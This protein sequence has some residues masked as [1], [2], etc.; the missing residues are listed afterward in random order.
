MQF[1]PY[2]DAVM[3]DPFPIYKQ[4]RDEARDLYVED[5]DC[6]FLSR[7]ED[8]HDACRNKAFSHRR[9]TTPMEL[10]QG[11]PVIGR[12]LAR[13][14]PPEH[15]HL[16]AALNPAFLPNAAKAMEGRVRDMVGRLLEEPMQTGALDAKDL[17]QRVAALVTFQIIG[18]PEQ[19]ALWASD[20]VVISARRD[21]AI[22]GVTPEGAQAQAALRDYLLKMADERRRRPQG[23]GLIET[24]LNFEFE[25]R[26]MPD[27]EV[28]DNLYLMVVGGTETVPRTFAGLVYQLWLNP[29]QR[30]AVIADPSL[31]QDAFWEAVRFDMPTLMLGAWAEEDT[32]ICGG[33]KVRRY[34]KIMNLWASA[35][36]D[37]REFP[38]P[39]RF[40]IHRK[41][42]RIVSFNPG[43]HICLGI[44]VAQMEGRIMLQELLARLPDY[45]VDEAGAVREK[46]EF[47]RGFQRLP[48][49][50]KAA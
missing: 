46:S 31:A 18:L 11:H 7:F 36:R 15:T 13:L 24:I 50:F 25:G 6:F 38:D 32:V 42:P 19:D 41:A 45:S 14:I 37:E 47:F 9:G 30:A 8:V 12:S 10:L 48:L 21:P 34:Q 2:A 49:R 23:R 40:D 20:Q 44:H 4:L 17:A 22:K 39:D 5:Y 28:L 33:T 1:D 26:R 35:N 43:R 29:D 27:E 3:T 16:R